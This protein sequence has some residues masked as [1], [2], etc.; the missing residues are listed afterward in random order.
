MQHQKK[1]NTQREEFLV[2]VNISKLSLIVP[3]QVVQKSSHNPYVR[4]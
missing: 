4:N 1:C 2:K 3:F